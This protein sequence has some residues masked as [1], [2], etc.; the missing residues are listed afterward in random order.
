MANI[1]LDYVAPVTV[2]A[3][4]PQASTAFLKQAVV[5]AKPKS[6][7]E[8][9][10]GILYL[11]TSMAQ[12]A[13]RTANTEAQQLFNAGMSQ[14]YILLADHLYDLED[15]SADIK[16]ISYTVLV[17]GDY[18]DADIK[19]VKGSVVKANLTFSSVAYGVG[20]NAISIEFLDTGTAGAEVVTVTDA[21]ISVSMEDGASTANQLKT[22]LDANPS[23]AALIT[24]AVASGQGST[25]QAAFAEAH[26]TSGAD[27][28]L[29]GTFDGVTVIQTQDATFAALQ[30]A[31]PNRA[32]FFTNVSNKAKNPFFAMGELLAN[33]SEW[34]NEQY[35]PMPFSD[36]VI[37]LGNANSLFNGKVSFVISDDQYSNRLG[38]L[39][40][41]GKAIIAPYILRNLIIDLQS[42]TLQWISGNQPQYTITEAS[43][44][45]TRL[46]EDVIN[47]YIARGWLAGGTVQISLVQQNFVA[48]GNIVVPEPKAMWRVF[49][50]MKQTP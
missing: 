38:L 7:Q 9:N 3:P 32:A 48:T 49:S 2:T 24:T 18:N 14:V 46:Q 30:A 23:A 33:Q 25:A 31:I 21:K 10:V 29:L 35:I 8:G 28:I 34:L 47:S 13:L 27:G 19:G 5:V 26:L 16:A 37:T 11:C 50:N 17:S 4:T 45:E 43:L 22:A 20:A 36:G 42:A 6:G 1:L 12:V 15:Y 44:L 40:A 39:A 41:G